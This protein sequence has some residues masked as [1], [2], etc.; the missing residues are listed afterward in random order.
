[1]KQSISYRP[2]SEHYGIP[3]REFM[4]WVR[5]TNPLLRSFP[6]AVVGHIKRKW[7][8]VPYSAASPRTM[9]DIYLPKEGEGPFPVA[10][11]VHGGAWM[12]GNK[13]DMQLFM[14]LRAL[15][16]GYAVAAVGYSMT[17]TAEYPTQLCEVKA[18]IRFLRSHA[19]EYLLDGTRMAL[20]GDSAGGHLAALAA[21]TATNGELDD[22]AMGGEGV[23]C[24]VSAVVDWFGPI[25]F[26]TADEQFAQS[27]IRNALFPW[28]AVHAP[29]AFLLGEAV[30]YC[31]DRVRLANPETFVHPGCPPFYILHGMADQ[32]VPYQQS[33]VFAGKLRL[34]IGEEKV[35]LELVPGKGHGDLS[36]LRPA[37]MERV[38]D[39]LDRWVKA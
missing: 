39:F 25:D 37:A 31:P 36:F 34:A 33:E 22:P 11:F 29:A 38:L 1:M 28:N 13:R 4:E 32:V 19:A 10:I 16:R 35:Q 21:V 15:P 27:G 14:A 20:L 23:D 9:L 24:G 7:L 30:P 2:V 18:A 6:P 3:K 26:S 8:D 12:T 5:H 17:D